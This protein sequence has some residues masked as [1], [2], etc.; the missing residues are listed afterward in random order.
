MA[1]AAAAQKALTKGTHKKTRKVRT[2]ATFNRPK[3]LKL[4]RKPT[5]S[6]FVKPL[7]PRLDQYA[8]LK[9][10]SN[11]ESALQKI[12]DLNTLT[13]IV[14]VRANKRQIKAAFKKMYDVDV[15]RVNTLIRYGFCFEV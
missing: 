7:T 3:T 2:S 15:L 1:K 13:F 12:E 6:R 8:I 5:Y 4:P 10:P 14:D 9:K 11:T